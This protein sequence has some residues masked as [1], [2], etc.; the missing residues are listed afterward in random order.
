MVTERRVTRRSQLSVVQSRTVWRTKLAKLNSSSHSTLANNCFAEVT[1]TSRQMDV[2]QTPDST[3]RRHQ[4]PPA[5]TDILPEARD[6]L[7]GLRHAPLKARHEGRG[8]PP[9][10]ERTG[11]SSDG[12]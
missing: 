1:H 7:C 9:P 11:E 8:L 3:A 2:A 10:A 5:T 6:D 12:P 4:E